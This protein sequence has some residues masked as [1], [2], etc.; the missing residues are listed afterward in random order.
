MGGISE[1]YTTHKQYWALDGKFLP[2]AVWE[3]KGFNVDDIQNNSRPSDKAKD[4]VLGEVFRVRIL[5]TGQSGEQAERESLRAK[6]IWKNSELKKFLE[7]AL[8]SAAEAVQEVEAEAPLAEGEIES[9]DRPIDK[10][11]DSS[12]SESSSDS[13]DS[14]DSSSSSERNKKKKKSSK[15]S[16]KAS[17]KEKKKKLKAKKKEQARQRKAKEAEKAK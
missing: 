16:K 8:R 9:E 14:S 5:T 10:P 6:S 7:D 17:K 3:K 13:S 12:D 11:D 2:L 4:P 1:K 15:E